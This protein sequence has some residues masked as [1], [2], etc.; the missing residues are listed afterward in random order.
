MTRVKAPDENFHKGWV[1]TV[2][3]DGERN[4]SEVW[5]FDTSQLDA[6]PICRLALPEV[7][8]IGFQDTWS[9]EY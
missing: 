1:L 7:I 2:I 9:Q 4:C 5:I 8:P 6:E 3:F